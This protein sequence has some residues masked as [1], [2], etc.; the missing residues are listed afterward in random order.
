M[1]CG[2]GGIFIFCYFIDTKGGYVDSIDRLGFGTVLERFQNGSGRV[3]EG[4]CGVVDNRLLAGVVLDWLETAWFVSSWM[5]PPRWP[6]RFTLL[7][8]A[9][10]FALAFGNRTVA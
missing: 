10:F 2:E 9:I 4:F 8:A 1:E 7:V 3:L 6:H 5:N